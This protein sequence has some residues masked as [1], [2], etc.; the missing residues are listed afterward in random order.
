MLDLFVRWPALAFLASAFFWALARW[1]R[2]RLVTLAA[3]AW[4]LYAVYEF[5]MQVR[6][7]CSGECNIRVDLLG[8]Y[9]VL[10]ALSLGAVVVGLAGRRPRPPGEVSE[11]RP[12]ER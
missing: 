10:A 7:L 8:I 9:P 3:V 6:V 11:P 12:N 2:R 4:G 1:S 5:L